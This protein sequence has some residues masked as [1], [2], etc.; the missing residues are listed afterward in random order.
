MLSFVEYE[1]VHADQ[2]EPVTFYT[3]DTL[4]NDLTDPISGSW[5]LFKIADNSIADT[6]TFGP[7]GGDSITRVEEGIY[8]F[9]FDAATYQ[10]EYDLAIKYI[11]TNETVAQDIFIK[12]LSS[13]YFA[14]AAHL[15]NQVDKARKSVKDEIENMDKSSANY[16]PSVQFFYGYSMKH[17]AFYLE[18]GC[19]Y[20][21]ALP[22]YTSLTV[23]NFP[24]DYYGSILIDAATIAALESQGIFAIDTDYSYSL[25]G[26]S[27]VID[28]FTKLSSFVQQI[29]NRF[30][31]IA[32]S[33]KQRYRSKG[34]V[35]WQ[36]T[37]GGMRT[38]RLYG[39]LPAGYWSRVLSAFTQ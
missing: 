30:Q 22:P 29:L 17:Y 3:R 12:P 16:N 31:S 39:V 5:T 15:S 19:Q 10:Y 2:I 1:V 18:R 11:M 20:L 28:H 14:Y 24:F 25:G 6:G 4:T 37:P 13:K 21:N 27:L 36:F 32:L 23:D 26:N 7:S 34:A 9:S 33:W 35:I 8:N 38:A